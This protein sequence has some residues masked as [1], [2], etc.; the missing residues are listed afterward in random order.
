MCSLHSWPTCSWLCKNH[1]QIWNESPYGGRLV[2]ATG[3]RGTVTSPSLC[4]SYTIPYLTSGPLGIT[5]YSLHTAFV[6]TQ[7]LEEIRLVNHICSLAELL[8]ADTMQQLELAL[9]GSPAA[10]LWDVLVIGTQHQTTSLCST[11]VPLPPSTTSST[12][13]SPPSVPI[14]GI[15]DTEE[16]CWH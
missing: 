10:R 9:L 8:H 2:N 7:T 14:A 1:G 5:I 16:T 3:Y 4:N 11:S 12:P 15:T 13:S 6:F